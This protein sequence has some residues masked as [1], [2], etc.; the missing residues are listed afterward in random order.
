MVITCSVRLS[1]TQVKGGNHDVD[2][3]DY[4]DLLYFC[5][6]VGLVVACDI[7]PAC[8]QSVLSE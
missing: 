6:L 7:S 3:D 8:N 4:L 5:P 2:L 1:V